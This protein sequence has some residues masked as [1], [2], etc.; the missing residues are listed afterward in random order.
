MQ[1]TLD[2]NIIYMRLK[3][4]CL[5]DINTI[6]LIESINCVHYIVCKKWHQIKYLYASIRS[7][8]KEQHMANDANKQK[9]ILRRHHVIMTP[10]MTPDKR[11]AHAPFIWCKIFGKYFFSG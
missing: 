2:I 7:V 3:Y 10:K 5:V 8:A 6:I 1:R 9:L 11:L 4:Y